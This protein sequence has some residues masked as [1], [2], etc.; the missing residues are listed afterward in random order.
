MARGAVHHPQRAPADEANGRRSSRTAG[1][2]VNVWSE[3]AACD[4]EEYLCADGRSCVS[5]SWLCDG[6]LDCPDGSDETP[7]ICLRQVKV[8]CP[9][10]H[11]QC[12]GT[13]RCV[14]FSKL[15]NGVRDCEDGYDEGV[16]CR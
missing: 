12:L 8:R 7:T 11:L 14:H 6:E 2:G 15:C 16:H 10:N 9:V 5:E 4:V 3:R 13:H 1:V